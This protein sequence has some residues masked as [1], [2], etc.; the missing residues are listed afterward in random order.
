MCG[1]V[2]PHHRAIINNVDSKEVFHFAAFCGVAW[3]MKTT[4]KKWGVG[5]VYDTCA[6][7]GEWDWEI[8]ILCYGREALAAKSVEAW[9]ESLQW[10]GQ[11]SGWRQG[12]QLSIY[13]YVRTIG[14]RIERMESME[15]STRDWMENGLRIDFSFKTRNKI[16][17]IVLKINVD[18]LDYVWECFLVR[19]NEATNDL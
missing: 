12:V 8:V 16:I 7:D 10:Q 18:G 14:R 11:A 19:S 6:S 17:S 5:R 3:W 15:R 9:G 13:I 2:S 1:L 4:K